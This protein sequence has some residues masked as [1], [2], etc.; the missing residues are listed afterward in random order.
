MPEYQGGFF[1]VR[2]LVIVSSW[3]IIRKLILGDEELSSDK[4][5]VR[6][7][8]AEYFNILHILRC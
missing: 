3:K 2:L 8:S 1:S 5:K 4:L 6:I 7:L